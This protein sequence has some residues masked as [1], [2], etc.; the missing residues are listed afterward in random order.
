ML[1]WRRMPTARLSELTW[2]EADG[3]NRSR[4]VALLPVGAVEAHGP[5]LPLATDG[6][7]A[8]SMVEAAAR[9]LAARDLIPLRLPGLDY[10]AAP[11]AAEFAGTI[12]I[13]PA[14][15]TALLVDIAGALSDW[16]VGTLGLANAHLDPAHLESLHRAVEE[17]R[18]PGR[19]RVA[20]PDLTRKPWAH[21]LTEEFKSG[22]CHAGRFEGSVLLAARPELVREEVRRGLAPNP[23]SLSRAI[24][25]GQ[26]TFL[27]AGGPQAYFGDP[28]AAT[29]EEGRRTIEVLGEILEE[30]VLEQ[31][32]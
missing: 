7:I 16:G 19:L 4:V 5:H 20:F 29:A 18:R 8:R 25:E 6:V 27:E 9:R 28:A 17:I 11:F 32:A 12:S 3:L 2:T 21:R 10:A 23:V 24:R 14:T 22:A 13:R 30:A 31:L 26:R 15:V 1:I